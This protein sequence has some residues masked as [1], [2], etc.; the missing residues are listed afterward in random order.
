[1]NIERPVKKERIP[2]A[3][4]NSFEQID[5]K[6]LSEYDVPDV[7]INHIR[8]FTE[9]KEHTRSIEVLRKVQEDGIVNYLVCNVS[10][11]GLCSGEV[12][13]V[14]GTEDVGETAFRGSNDRQGNSIIKVLTTYTDEGLRGVGLAE[15]RLVT[16]NDYCVKRFGT[17]L[18]A[19]AAPSSA[20]T[21]L[22]EGLRARGLVEF[23]TEGAVDRYRF[24]KV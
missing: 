20:A 1:M 16:I 18:S 2:I 15:R 24:K 23:D 4:I 12:L 10:T 21:R 22:W 19:S 8:F 17:V 11:T 7:A 14:L 13:D 9:A 3:D 6:K 5:P